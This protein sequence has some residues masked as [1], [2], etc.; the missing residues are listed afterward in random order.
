MGIKYNLQTMQY[1]TTFE[2]LTSARVKDCFLMNK[3]I[4]VVDE[5]E[6]G[7]AVGKNGGNIK[8]IEA[9]LKKKIRVIEYSN[10]ILKFV[11][12]LIYPITA[13]SIV[14]ENNN[15]T[16]FVDGV[17]DK[18]RIIGRDRKNINELKHIISRYFKIG[19]IKI[20]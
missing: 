9:I 17:Q 15:I 8:K 11:K 13:K 7:R 12:N 2:N 19:D 10:D 14:Q 16:I 20:A 1:R 3:L 4:I 18:G 5:G 6:L